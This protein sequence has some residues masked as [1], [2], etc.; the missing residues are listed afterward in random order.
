[1]DLL[2]TLG[3]QLRRDVVVLVV[4]DIHMLE[5]AH[6][7]AL[8]THI[9]R[10]GRAL[11]WGLHSSRGEQ[12]PIEI[13][14]LHPR[15][16]YYDLSAG[17]IRGIDAGMTQRRR[18]L[19]FQSPFPLPES[20]AGEAGIRWVP[21][22]E[23]REP[24]GP[25]KGWPAS[26]VILAATN[27]PVSAWAW[28]AWEPDR[29]FQ[30][31]QVALLRRAARFLMNTRFLLSA[32]TR[33]AAW[34]PGDRI[35]L[36]LAVIGSAAE[37][38]VVRL[39]L[40]IENAKGSIERRWA[41]F[42][43][44]D[45]TLA[46]PARASA[47]AYLGDVP[48]AV[49]RDETWRIRIGLVD[50][51]NERVL[52]HLSIPMPLLIES[53]P[54]SAFREARPGT[55]GTH[56][57]FG[58]RPSIVA[59]AAFD[60]PFGSAN[61]SALQPPRFR[62]DRA[63]YELDSI[64]EIGLNL[65]SVRYSA[66]EE[67]P[68][69]RFLLNELRK[70]RMWALVILPAR[71]SWNVEAPTTAELLKA[72]AL[73]SDHNLLA[74]A[75]DVTPPLPSDEA[76]CSRIRAAWARWLAE[77]A[78]AISDEELKHAL[79][80]DPVLCLRNATHGIPAESEGALRLVASFFRDAVGRGL[81]RIR[82][83][84]AQQAPGALF[85]ALGVE[86]YPAFAG[87]PY[88][89]F[90]TLALPPWDMEHQAIFDFLTAYARGF[91]GGKPV[92]WRLESPATRYPPS[93]DALRASAQ[94]LEESIRRLEKAHAAGV[95][96]GPVF[97]APRGSDAMDG[98]LLNPDGS[99]RPAG[100]IARARVNEWKRKTLTIPSFLARESDW[101][102][103]AAWREWE[104]PQTQKSTPQE[105]L[106]IR[107]FNRGR[108]TRD[109][110]GGRRALT[111]EQKR[112]LRE[113]LCADWISPMPPGDDAPLGAGLRRPVSLEVVNTGFAS[114]TASVEGEPGSVWIRATHESGRVHLLPIRDTM[115]GS[116]AIAKWTPAD[117]GDWTL[118]M[119]V[120]AY[121]EFGEALRVQVRATTQ[122]NSSESR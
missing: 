94:V 95:L 46:A 84:A 38:N 93:P 86:R 61:L 10:G 63:I 34:A 82:L 22:A 58:R 56:F 100:E 28:I 96:F 8:A 113:H 70:R 53:D 59:G 102:I 83:E 74:V 3:P 18:P 9:R 71:L 105:P 14:M 109:W 79:E 42:L 81:R 12:A 31:A 29:A 67:A 41:Q 114:W 77:Q 101:L 97:G 55:R 104:S 90:V 17:E 57:I 110:I 121:G 36:S 13:A 73:P 78:D 45:G 16:E 115:P 54:E 11:F 72:L 25:V 89:D 6:W 32:E 48:R 62:P 69:V 5:P 122:R 65:V 111:D 50:A 80:T 98:G 23:A 24:G 99:W 19:R 106:E 118:R 2:V 108:S 103:P 66:I 85:T 37:T 75:V 20:V 88:V 68:Q 40:E 92:M 116:R 51:R 117:P 49:G 30:E 43:T 26:A 7:Q 44:V 112:M 35:D 33:R 120:P 107:P 76:A 60:P 119:W 39:N 47:L 87:L 52:D 21:I 15:T 64:S 1:M 27:A 4:P 91:S